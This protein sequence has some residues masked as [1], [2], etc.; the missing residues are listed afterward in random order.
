MDFKVQRN[1][2]TNVEVDAIVCPQNPMLKEGPGTSVAIFEK[3]G[4]SRLKKACAQ[5][6]EVRV[7]STVV[8]SAFDLPSKIIL[9]TV[10]PKWRGGNHHEYE[11]LCEAYLSALS[12][13]D[14]AGCESLAF[15]LLSSGNNGFDLGLAAG[16]A[17]RSIHEFEPKNK[18]SL[19]YLVT[20]GRRA[21][22]FMRDRGY[23]VEDIIDERYVQENDERYKSDVVHAVNAAKDAAQP[24]VDQAIKV[25]EDLVNDPEFQ[26]KL[27]DMAVG[28][29]A[30]VV[31]RK[32]P[33]AGEV[34]K[35]LNT[36]VGR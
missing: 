24:F 4:R 31:E 19:V 16:V 2:I 25:A 30:G 9:H 12:V 17:I 32:V 36:L 27:R 1:D 22:Q 11:Q 34:L 3:A 21:T 6:G 23:E 28:I 14:S 13:A 15:P 8:T 7:G 20:Y 33:G 29:V 10:V 18:L 5:K 35:V 26:V